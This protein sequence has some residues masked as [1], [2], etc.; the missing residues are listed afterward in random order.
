MIVCGYNQTMDTREIRKWVERSKARG[1]ERE[2]L[3]EEKATALIHFLR[4]PL[5]A[6][7]SFPYKLHQFHAPGPAH[8]TQG[9]RRQS[10]ERYKGVHDILAPLK[11][12]LPSSRSDMP[13]G[14]H[15]IVIGT[16]ILFSTPMHMLMLKML[17]L[18]RETVVS[19]LQVC[20]PIQALILNMH[21]IHHK[22]QCYTTPRQK[23]CQNLSLLIQICIHTNVAPL[24]M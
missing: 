2:E 4:Y 17:G 3:D 23:I 12:G 5:P 7:A 22:L 20:N 14:S 10:P 13:P 9:P 16:E 11:S 1:G 18:Y 21:N 19:T 6:A 8:G 24:S 15:S